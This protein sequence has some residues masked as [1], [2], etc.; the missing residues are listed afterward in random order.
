MVSDHLLTMSS[1][2]HV[3]YTTSYGPFLPMSSRVQVLCESPTVSSRSIEKHFLLPLRFRSTCR[4]FRLYL[5]PQHVGGT[6]V[7]VSLRLI[8]EGPFITHVV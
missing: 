3:S 1:G 7:P 8:C 6:S 5:F 2:T 4:L